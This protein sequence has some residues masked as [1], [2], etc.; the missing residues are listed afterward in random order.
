LILSASGVKLEPRK[1]IVS[2]NEK[3][4]EGVELVWDITVEFCQKVLR[5]T[6]LYGF[7]LQHIADPDVSKIHFALTN[8][9]I[10]IL[11]QL[12]DDPNLSSDDGLRIANIKQ[13]LHHI[14]LIAVAIRDDD[15]EGFDNAV[16]ALRQESF[17]SLPR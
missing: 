2:D 4:Q 7:N 1:S 3:I 15:E 8:V 5:T 12:K 10:P 9:V 17:I 16:K 6:G 11:E 14:K 13:Y